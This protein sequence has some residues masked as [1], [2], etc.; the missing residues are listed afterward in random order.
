MTQNLGRRDPEPP[1]GSALDSNKTIGTQQ[2]S[3]NLHGILHDHGVPKDLIYF[4][5]VIGLLMVVAG[6]GLDHSR[7]AVGIFNT[8]DVCWIRIIARC[9]QFEGKWKL[10]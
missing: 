6:I 8:H 5:I 4:A 1:G 10:G 3:P 9:F 2:S 7:K